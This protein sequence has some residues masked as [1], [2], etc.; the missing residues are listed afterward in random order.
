MTRVTRREFATGLAGAAAA[1]AAGRGARAATPGRIEPS[2]IG[3]IEVGVQSFTYRAFGVDRMI[4]SMRSVGL[5]NVEL[6]TGHLDP[7]KHTEADF[8]TVRGKLDAAGIRVSAYCVNFKPDATADLLDKAFKGAGLLGTS[9]M[10]TS[11]EKSIIPKLDEWA[12]KYKVTIGIHNHWFGDAWF[13]GDRSQNFETPDDFMGALHGRSKHMAINL[14]IGHFSAAGQDPVAFF[15]EHHDRIMSLHVKDRDKDAT[16]SNRKFGQ[17]AT[18]ITQVLKLA[19][20][21]RFKY[22]A[23]IEW[24][25][26]E[27]EPTA[28]VKDSFEYMKRVLAG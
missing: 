23:N 27:Q 25:E 7:A 28:G 2:I 22:A 4:E 13:K 10:T 20:Q 11:T 15:K 9:L 3:G 21:M 18:P 1:L 26:D 8:R 19:Q 24:E 17:G 5:S 6:W 16:H 14:D 12:R